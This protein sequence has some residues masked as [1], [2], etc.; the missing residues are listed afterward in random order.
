MTATFFDHDWIAKARQVKEQ[1]DELKRADLLK[2]ICLAYASRVTAAQQQEFSKI[3][4]ITFD[5]ELAREGYGYEVPA[6]PEPQCFETFTEAVKF[7]YK[8]VNKECDKLDLL[9]ASL[10]KERDELASKYVQDMLAAEKRVDYLR[11]SRDNC[12]DVLMKIAMIVGGTGQI[13]P[14]VEKLKERVDELEKALSV[15]I[16]WVFEY[17]AHQNKNCY[18][19]SDDGCYCGLEEAQNIIK[20]VEG[21]GEW[22]AR[23]ALKGEK[24]VNRNG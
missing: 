11:T 4:G 16:A 6:E 14:K 10:T 15:A 2:S 17:A 22:I 13:P 23:E 9:V 21:H 8:L 5:E 24:E 19:G 1:K 7:A 3:F 18:R 12:A 20:N